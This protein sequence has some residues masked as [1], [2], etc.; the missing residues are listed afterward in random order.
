MSN[1]E[2]AKKMK[3]ILSSPDKDLREKEKEEKIEEDFFAGIPR[4]EPKENITTEKPISDIK[5]PSPTKK[6]VSTQA[7]PDER[8]SQEKFL[9][10]LWTITSAISM[11]VNIVVVALLIGLYQNYT[12]LKIPEKIGVDTPKELL[13]GLYDNFQ[14]MDVAHIKTNIVV[15]DE[16]PVQF[17]LELNQATNVTLSEDVTISG[18]YVVINTSTIN[19][20]APA[21]VT[22]PAG[23]NLPIVL[24]LV[25]PV[26]KQVPVKL[27]VPVDIALEETDLHKPFVGLQEVVQPLYCLVSPNAKKAGGEALCP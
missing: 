3:N 14:L 23:T 19:I 18:A 16:I 22:L 2:P 15:E 24:N 1:S 13:Q 5:K 10:A 21:T 4:N 12:V 6:P 20:N 17:D 7:E 9:R 27:N 11:L 26:D 25:V 8:S